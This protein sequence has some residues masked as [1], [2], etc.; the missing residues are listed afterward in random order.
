M[1]TRIVTRGTDI[2]DGLHAHILHSVQKL[3]RCYDGIYDAR[4]VLGGSD[5]AA[6]PKHA[7]VTLSVRR[8]RLH[9]EEAGSTHLDAVNACVRRLRRQV[10]RYKSRLRSTKQDRHR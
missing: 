4:V 3:G 6:A 2:P 10:L 7:E 5:D 1:Q 9:A 8:G